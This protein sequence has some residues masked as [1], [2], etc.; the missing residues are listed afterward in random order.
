MTASSRTFYR[1]VFVV[2]VLSEEPIPDGLDFAHTWQT[3]VDGDYSGTAMQLV[4][5]EVDG[6]TM[7]QLLEAQ[8]SDPGFFRLTSD[9]Q[10][11]TDD[12]E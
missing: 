10:E 3:C 11:A 1:T 9:G 5:E 6:P 4:A 7:A 8:G 2:E 12:S